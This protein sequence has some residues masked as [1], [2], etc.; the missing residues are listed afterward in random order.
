MNN[1]KFTNEVLSKI[2]E[3]LAL[4]NSI[5]TVLKELNLSWEGFRLL[6]HKKPKIRTE[7]EQAKADG[8]NY[9][10]DNGVD[11]LKKAIEDIKA[12]PNQKN[13]LAIT[14]LQKEI[15]GLLRFKASHLLPKYNQKAQQ[16]A[17]SNA[18]DKP[19]VIKWSKD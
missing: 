10:L 12:E 7:Y 2:Y 13:G 9:L 17:L 11:S 3:Q 5:K 15:I 8:V 18:N 19:L 14:H 1:I 6:M 4:G 16:I